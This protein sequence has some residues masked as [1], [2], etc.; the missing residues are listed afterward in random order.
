MYKFCSLEMSW[1]GGRSGGRSMIAE[2]GSQQRRDLD[3]TQVL[4]IKWVIDH[5][6]HYFD[7]LY[8]DGRGS[9]LRTIRS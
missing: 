4:W 9:S 3:V 6:P 1:E 5:R 7:G 2:N 8:R